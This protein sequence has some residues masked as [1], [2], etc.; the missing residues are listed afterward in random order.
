[1][2]TR[3]EY[4]Q[5]TIE[6]R[7]ARLA[8]TPD[9]LAAAIHGQSD[10]VLSRRPDA[11][12]WSA[13]EV[14]CHLR[15]VEELFM[16]RFQTML[17]MPTPTFLVLGELPP[18]PGQWGLGGGVEHVYDPDRWAEERQYL[19]N[20][21]VEALSALRRR[22][23]ES[24]VFLRRLTCRRFHD[25]VWDGPPV[26]SVLVSPIA[27]AQDGRPKAARGIMSGNPRGDWRLPRTAYGQAPHRHGGAPK[28]VR[29]E[30]PCS[31]CMCPGLHEPA[32]RRSEWG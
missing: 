30:E 10:A 21:T 29:P 26:H 8:C 3:E 5:Q 23:T 27:A 16:M 9:D 14:I 17:A 31:I 12:N 2:P 28:G 22:R 7:L 11:Q 6:S 19:R 25:G 20:D 24:L 15:D 4:L 13:K 1:M 32:V 18:D